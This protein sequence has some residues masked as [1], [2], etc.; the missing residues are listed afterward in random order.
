MSQIIASTYEV[1]GELGAGGGGIVY[2]ANHLRLNKKV[3][4]KADKRNI[5]TREVLLRREV[6]VLKELHHTY[7]PQVYDYFIENDIS[8][9]AMDFVDGESLDKLLIREKRFNQPTVIRWAKQLLEA[10]AYLH[11]PIHGDPPRGYIHSDV[12]PANLMRRPNGDICLIDFNISL[13][14]GIESV[15]GK[16]EGYSSPEHYGLDY[17]SGLQSGSGRSI[18]RNSSLFAGNADRT[19][20]LDGE[21]TV[22]L[23]NENSTQANAETEVLTETAARNS[24]WSSSVRRVVVPDARSDIYSVGATLYHLLSGRRPAKDAKDVVPLSR[25][26]F[27]P[28]LVDIITKAMDPD[29]DLRFSTAEEML[30]ALNSLWK[31]DSRVKRQ[32]KRLAAACSLL[33][34]IF[35][36]GALTVFAGLRQME[37]IQ[38]AQVLAADSAEAL[39]RGDVQ[40]AIDRALEALVDD[41][42]AFDIPYTAGAQLALTNA[43]GVYDLSDSFKPYYTIE[44]PSAPFRVLRSPDETKIMVCYAYELAIY[45]IDSGELIRSLP[46]LESAFCEVEF[47]SDT[48]ILYAGKDGLTAYDISSGAVLWQAGPATSIAVS[49]DKSVAAAIHRTDDVIYFYDTDSGEMISF[50]SLDG[51]HLN[52]PEN[53]RFADL[54]IDVFEMNEDGSLCAVSLT[55]GY[56]GILDIYN[57]FNDLVIYEN[58][59]YLIF[60]GKF[61]EDLFVFSASVNSDSTWGLV[62]YKMAELLGDIPETSPV[63]IETYDGRLYVSRNDEVFMIDTG[64]LDMY[65]VAYTENND[66]TAFDI[67]DKYV[68][69]AA[70]EGYTIFYGGGGILQTDPRD[71]KPDF[72]LVTD[73]CAV[74]ADMN[75]PVI[76]VMKHKDSGDSVIINYDPKIY[77]DEARLAADRSGVMLFNI[78]SITIVNADGSIRAVTELPEPEKIFDQQYRHE[79]D[80]LEV[81]YYSGKVVCYSAVTGEIIS[82]TSVAP[83]DESLY[84]EFETEDLIIKAPLHGTPAAYDKNTGKEVAELNS[85]DTLTYITETGEYIIAQYISVQ[86]NAYGILMNKDCEPIARLPYLCDVSGDTLIYDF[87]S[88][89]IKIS[90]IYELN[91]LKEMAKNYRN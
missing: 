88:G 55:D 77:H 87:P 68:I 37:R 21:K 69:S 52:V 62:N 90:P 73:T 31:K 7:I 60:D 22:L 72:V 50:R 78:Y 83:P 57:E 1:I 58:S 17:S 53:D 48:E 81:I 76:E 61:I 79:G 59:P 51:R 29:P 18:L 65:R 14:I 47:L 24:S 91:E 44:L 28:L 67:S 8:Y 32:K 85:E 49:G 38:N 2:L 34:I 15:V 64:T 4:L 46:T 43:L 11:S 9:T 82:E 40:T 70:G 66:I 30:Q 74:L 27:S 42:G 86:G 25:S 12:K 45:D 13:A 75:S 3:V 89:N 54:D 16:S 63:C 33:S 5:S 84:E 36:A 26:E 56:L 10:L 6:D 80:Y 71:V 20:L 35:I 19:E 39:S 23:E 41:P